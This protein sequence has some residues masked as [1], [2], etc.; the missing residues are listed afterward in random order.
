MSVR[1][2]IEAQASASRS[3]YTQSSRSY[4]AVVK[5]HR[6]AGDADGVFSGCGIRSCFSQSEGNGVSAKVSRPADDRPTPVA[7]ID[8]HPHN[9]ST[10]L[11]LS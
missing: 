2:P 4:L 10:M 6:E 11:V 1:D 9:P 5:A 7:I 3:F 8:G